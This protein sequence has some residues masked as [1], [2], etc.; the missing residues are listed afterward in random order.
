MLARESSPADLESIVFF[1]GGPQFQCKT[2]FGKASQ[3]LG[4]TTAPGAHFRV[5]CQ[6]RS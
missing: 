1:R 6:T 2:I 4:A 5:L 3:I